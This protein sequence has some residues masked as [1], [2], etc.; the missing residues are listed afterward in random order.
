MAQPKQVLQR[1]WDPAA[2]E[3]EKTQAGIPGQVDG[4]REITIEKNVFI[5]M[6]KKDI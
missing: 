6:K 1:G 2:P 3:V 4:K 5:S